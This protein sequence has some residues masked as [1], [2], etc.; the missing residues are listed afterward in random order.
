MGT[1]GNQ[2]PLIKSYCIAGN[3]I[4]RGIKSGSNGIGVNEDISFTLTTGDR[5]AVVDYYS[6]Q[7]SDEYKKSNVSHTLSQRDYK[8]A[9]DLCITANSVVR[10]LTPL[11]CERLQG[12]PDNWTAGGSNT[13]RYKAIGNGMAQP[14]ANFIMKRIVEIMKMAVWK[15]KH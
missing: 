1:G 13:A 15:K 12:L 3:I 9:T 7:R 5:H 8:S 4:D 14:C 6:F 2:I 10:R 11:E